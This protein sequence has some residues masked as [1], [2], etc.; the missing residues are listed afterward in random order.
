MV[1]KGFDV[2]YH[3]CSSDNNSVDGVVF[4][5]VGV[6]FIDGTAPPCSR[7]NNSPFMDIQYEHV[8]KPGNSRDLL[9]YVAEIFFCG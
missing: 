2:E 5:Q 6:A 7:R 3:H 4:P 8:S 9:E 1:E